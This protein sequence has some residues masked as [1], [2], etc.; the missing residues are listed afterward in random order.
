MTW[1]QAIRKARR[2]EVQVT[3]TD[4][5][6]WTRISKQLAIQLAEEGNGQFCI[7]TTE[8]VPGCVTVEPCSCEARHTEPRFV[9]EERLLA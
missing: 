7:N 9:G 4:D 6:F 3:G 2:V 5:I 1:R 8:F